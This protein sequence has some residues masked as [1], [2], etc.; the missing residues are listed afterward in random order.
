MAKPDKATRQDDQYKRQLKMLEHYLNGRLC[1]LENIA[2]NQPAEAPLC[3]MAASEL[4]TVLTQVLPQMR[5]V[6]P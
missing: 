1:Q 6:L 3:E 2:R 5:E 4:R